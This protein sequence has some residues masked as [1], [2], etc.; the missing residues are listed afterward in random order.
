[1]KRALQTKIRHPASA[2]SASSPTRSPKARALSPGIGRSRVAPRGEAGTAAVNVTDNITVTVAT[3]ETV[4]TIFAGLV[5]I[6]SVDVGA[7]ATAVCGV[8]QSDEPGF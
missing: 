1:M 5:S 7:D 8:N 4:G 6:N 3:R 2:T